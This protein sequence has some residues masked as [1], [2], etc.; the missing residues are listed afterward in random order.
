MVARIRP[1]DLAPTVELL[2]ERLEDFAFPSGHT[3]V[4]FEAAMVLTVYHRR[5]GIAA[6][7]LALLIGFS[8]LY[9]FVHYPTDVLA[10]ILLGVTI[11]LLS[12][13][14]VNALWDKKPK[15]Q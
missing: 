15:R 6:L 13:R 2:I 9:L 7:A 10:S 8:R 1:Y 12:C 5:V 11:G 4:S 14:L 3:L